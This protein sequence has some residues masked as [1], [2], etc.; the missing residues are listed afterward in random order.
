MTTVTQ[1]AWYAS[2]EM[3]EFPPPA[4]RN[5]KTLYGQ[6]SYCWLCGG[7][8]HQKGWRHKDGLAP[9]FCDHN[10][11][12]RLDSDTVCEACVATSSTKGWITYASRYPERQLWTHF[13]KKGEKEPRAFNW[14]YGSHVFTLGHH[15]SPDRKRWREILLD[16]PEPPFVLI[17]TVS[18]KKQLVFRGRISHSKDTFWLQCEDQKVLINRLPFSQCLSD[19]EAL[20]N[21]G[22]SKDSIVT[23]HYHTGQL[24]KTGMKW[25]ALEANI[26]HWRQRF[27][28]YMT[29]CH[30]CAQKRDIEPYE[31]KVGAEPEHK[32]EKIVRTK[33]LAP[34]MELF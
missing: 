12:K 21:E 32:P 17:M 11:A 7:E 16:P 25:R 24:A 14:L 15:E 34:Q 30:F 3:G 23:G 8:T 27:P 4:D 31:P 13:P 2:C 19:F 26:K 1:F 33:P 28:D 5:G 10:V 6:H 29:V 20:Y 22:F 9:T 18:G